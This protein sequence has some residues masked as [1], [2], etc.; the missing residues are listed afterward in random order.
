M[1]FP[2]DLSVHVD[3]LIGLNYMFAGLLLD[4]GNYRATQDHSSPTI[5]QLLDRWSI[6]T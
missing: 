5:R 2:L 4:R 3:F 6:E 1:V